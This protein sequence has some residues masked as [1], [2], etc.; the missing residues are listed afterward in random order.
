MQ[1]KVSVIIPVY[2]IEKY[3]RECIDSVVNQT[4][5][6][7]QIILVD[8]GSTDNSGNICKEYAKKYS[9][10]EYY[11]KKNGG[12]ASARNMGLDYAVGEYVG[13]MDSDDWVEPDMFEKMY[14]KAIEENVDIIFCRTFENECPG[15]YEYVMPRSGYY[16][17]DDMKK[18]IFPYLLPSVMPKGN[19]RN[20]RWCNWLR[21]YRRDIIEENNIRFYDK[22]R[23]CEDLGFSVACTIRAK[24]YYVLDE[25]LYHNRPNAASKSRNY[26]KEMWKSIR[27]LMLYLKKITSECQEYDFTKNMEVCIFYFV[28]MVIRNEMLL[29]DKKMRKVQIQEVL[30]DSLCKNILGNINSNGMNKEYSGFCTA[31]QTGN[32]DKVIRYLKVLKWKKNTLY[33]FLARII[34]ISWI[35]GLYNKV[36]F[37]WR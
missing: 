1:P 33:P 5:K 3:L 35:K 23:R 29:K 19:F 11:Y 17:L 21:L 34:S 4:L 30:S 25:C 18:E 14:Y 7:I 31:I 12:S 10:V 27:E 9:T 24:N 36:R 16:S 32:A 13:F 2:N 22:S 26:T 37:G 15:A 6:E 28:T 20:I 8:D